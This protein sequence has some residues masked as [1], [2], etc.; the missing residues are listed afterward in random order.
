MCMLTKVWA[1]VPPTNRANCRSSAK[2]SSTVSP[3]QSCRVTN[4]PYALNASVAYAVMRACLICS[5]S[6]FCSML[7][8]LYMAKALPSQS[9]QQDTLDILHNAKL[10]HKFNIFNPL[11]NE[12]ISR[13]TTKLRN[14]PD[15]KHLALHR[16]KVVSR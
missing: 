10:A 9:Q 8:Y 16:Q 5:A 2:N 1:A 4:W 3:G 15:I 11:N 13:S 14:Q 6:T 7:G 12:H